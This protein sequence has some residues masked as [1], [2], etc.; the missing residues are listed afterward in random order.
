MNAVRTV[1]S[2]R[3]GQRASSL[4]TDFVRTGHP[5]S[6]AL[7]ELNNVQCFGSTGRFELNIRGVSPSRTER[8]TKSRLVRG[9]ETTATDTRSLKLF[10]GL[11]ETIWV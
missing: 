11:Y 9:P 4:C 1:C 2:V 10:A 5:G 8:V 6:A 7:S 3:T